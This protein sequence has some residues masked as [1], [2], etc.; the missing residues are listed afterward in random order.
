MSVVNAYAQ[1]MAYHAGDEREMA[2]CHKEYK[3]K[4]GPGM[5]RETMFKVGRAAHSSRARLCMA[6]TAPRVRGPF[7]SDP[8]VPVELCAK[9]GAWKDGARP[10][11]SL[12]GRSAM[13]TIG[14]TIRGV[15]R[16]VLLRTA[17]RSRQ[18]LSCRSRSILIAVLQAGRATFDVG[19][20]INSPLI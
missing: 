15:G 4:L 7:G 13:A 18:S 11:Y 12:G 6:P 14:G 1:E 8:C 16:D 17:L 5:Y 10:S 9:E 19:D 3:G 2:L 20:V